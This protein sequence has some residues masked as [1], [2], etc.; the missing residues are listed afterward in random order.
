MQ[1][2]SSGEPFELDLACGSERG[3][4]CRRIG[5][6]AS[7]VL[8]HEDLAPVVCG[9]ARS[10]DDRAT[11]EIVAFAYDF[12]GVKADAHPQSGSVRPEV[13]FVE[14]ALHRDGTCMAAAGSA[15]TTMNP[16]PALFTMLPE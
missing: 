16:S 9:D 1:P 13:V 12:S 2:V 5:H 7:N 15:K 14:L 3:V 10:D 6:G 11:E 8:G 4:A